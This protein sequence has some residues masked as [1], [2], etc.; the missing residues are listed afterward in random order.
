MRQSSDRNVQRNK[1]DREEEGLVIILPAGDFLD[2][3]WSL[4][5]T[6]LGLRAVGDGTNRSGKIKQLETLKR[7]LTFALLYV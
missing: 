2:L 7:L 5:V 4:P 6:Q 1:Q 3:T